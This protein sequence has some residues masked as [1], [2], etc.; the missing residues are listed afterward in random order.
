M[1][2]IQPLNVRHYIIRMN[3]PFFIRHFF[4]DL[5][6]QKF[7]EI[8]CPQLDI[9]SVMSIHH[10]FRFFFPIFIQKTIFITGYFMCKRDK[11]V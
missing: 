5:E 1:R 2:I 9:P 11:P 7:L 6:I 3:F 8:V 10:Y 4:N